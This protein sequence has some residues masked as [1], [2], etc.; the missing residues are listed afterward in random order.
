MIADLREKT[1]K[2]FT[3]AKAIRDSCIAK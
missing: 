1:N 3:D 2:L